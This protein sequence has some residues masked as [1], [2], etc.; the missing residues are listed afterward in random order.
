MLTFG[1]HSG[2]DSFSG[3]VSHP[4]LWGAAEGM[5]FISQSKSG[6]HYF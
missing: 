3:K 2:A 1:H 5:N 6:H 4:V